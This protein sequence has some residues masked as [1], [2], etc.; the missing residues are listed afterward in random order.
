MNGGRGM[1]VIGFLLCLCTE[2]FVRI[3]ARETRYNL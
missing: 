2:N 1:G 3:P